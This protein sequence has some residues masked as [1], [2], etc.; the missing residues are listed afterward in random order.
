MRFSLKQQIWD[1]NCLP[2]ATF[3]PAMRCECMQGGYMPTFSLNCFQ[4]GQLE[5][6]FAEQGTQIPKNRNCKVAWHVSISNSCWQL[7][8]QPNCIIGISLAHTFIDKTNLIFL[9]VGVSWM[10]SPVWPSVWGCGVKAPPLE[11][12][13]TPA[14]NV[15]SP[16]SLVMEWKKEKLP[17]PTLTRVCMNVHVLSYSW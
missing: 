13:R 14:R 2:H 3:S 12:A 6:F 11:R 8:C 4:Q 7:V 9:I 16:W 1:L 17:L 5:I 10:G 15:A